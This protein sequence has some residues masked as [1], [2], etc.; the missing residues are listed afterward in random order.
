MKSG[1]LIESVSLKTVKAGRGLKGR[2]AG[3]CTKDYEMDS[4]LSIS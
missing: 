3:Y 2:H 4:P 1:L